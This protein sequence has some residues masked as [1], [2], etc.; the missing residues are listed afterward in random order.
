MTHNLES[1]PHRLWCTGTATKSMAW[2]RIRHL[3]GVVVECWHDRNGRCRP[4]TADVRLRPAHHGLDI[5]RR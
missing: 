5:A 3:I 4:P 2:L 1:P